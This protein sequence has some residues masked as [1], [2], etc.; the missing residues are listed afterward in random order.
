MDPSTLFPVHLFIRII[1]KMTAAVI[2]N[3]EVFHVNKHTF[4]ALF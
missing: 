4:T 2:I 1:M 3:Y